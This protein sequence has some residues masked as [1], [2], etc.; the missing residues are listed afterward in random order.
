MR[1]IVPPALHN[2]SRQQVFGEGLA[3]QGQAGGRAFGAAA[4]V[5]GALGD[6]VHGGL[7]RR[8]G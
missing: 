8:V 1:R 2:R 5:F 6:R 3:A 7:Q 4:A